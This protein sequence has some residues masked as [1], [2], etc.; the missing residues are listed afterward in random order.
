MTQEI[1]HD[2][3]ALRVDSYKMDSAHLVPSA[4][5][6][7]IAQS[8][9]DIEGKSI[10]DGG[11]MT[12]RI[13]FVEGGINRAPRIERANTYIRMTMHCSM[14]PMVLA[15]LARSDCYVTFEDKP[16]TPVGYVRN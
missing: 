7:P 13:A 9:I 2:S 10:K 1:R 3:W 8:F 15:Q 5:S 12:A 11:A 16:G 4:G 14:I 6:N